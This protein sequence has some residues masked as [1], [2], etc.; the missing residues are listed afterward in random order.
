MHRETWSKKGNNFALEIVR[1]QHPNYING[2]EYG[3]KY[4]WNIYCYIYPKHRLFDELKIEDIEGGYSF[5][6]HMGCS[7]CKWSRNKQRK[8][9]CKQYG[10]D[11]AH[12]GDEEFDTIKNIE[13][14]Y[15]IQN[16]AEDLFNELDKLED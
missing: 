5:N 6:F 16:D 13:D 10:C 1:W 12:Y 11:Y 15:V 9:E 4:V 7:F 14:N 8:V 2:K 3:V